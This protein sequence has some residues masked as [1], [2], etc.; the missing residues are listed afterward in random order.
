MREIH[1][2]YNKEITVDGVKFFADHN[3]NLRFV[4]FSFCNRKITTLLKTTN[5]YTHIRF[6]GPKD[7]ID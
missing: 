4:D 1:L 6:F 2:K 7:N 5:H 3:P